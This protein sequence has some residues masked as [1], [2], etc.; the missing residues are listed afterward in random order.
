MD[1][2]SPNL[3]LRN[4]TGKPKWTYRGWKPSTARFKDRITET[5]VNVLIDHILISS[6]LKTHGNTPCKIW[7]PFENEEAKPLKNNLLEASDHFPI[8]LDLEF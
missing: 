5:Y 2:F 3:I 7:N 6:G 8:T 1:I 4:F